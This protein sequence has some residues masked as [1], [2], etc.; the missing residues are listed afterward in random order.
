MGCWRFK[1]LIFGAADSQ[2]LVIATVREHAKRFHDRFPGAAEKN[3]SYMYV[4]DLITLVDSEEEAI[5]LS[6]DLRELMELAGMRLRKWASNNEKV[7][8]DIPKADRLC[9]DEFI[10][11]TDKEAGCKALGF[12]IDCREDIFTFQ[13]LTK[14]TDLEET[15]MS[16]AR[17]VGKFGYD[18][19]GFY[20]PIK[21]GARKVLKHC[22]EAKLT[23]KDS[24]PIGLATSWQSWLKTVD[25]M[26]RLKYPRYV[27]DFNESSE[28]NVFGDASKEAFGACAYLRTKSGREW[29]SNFLPLDK[30]T[31]MKEMTIPNLELCEV[32][33][34]GFVQ[35]VTPTHSCRRH[36]D[37]D[38]FS[39]KREYKNNGTFRHMLRWRSSSGGF[40]AP[41][42]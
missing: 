24:L 37:D 25:C 9:K 3:L 14:L 38:D 16:V 23:W 22:F 5:Q 6:H 15:M 19:I 21:L 20:Q 13:G 10:F 30:V 11:A 34:F 29:Q 18:P 4:D 39:E 32:A 12:S 2:L 41:R 7:L 28:I 27:G 8:H 26:D 36:D 17:I 1:K 42:L 33:R 35:I 40:Y 31:P